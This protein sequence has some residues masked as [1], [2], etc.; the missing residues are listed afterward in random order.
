LTSPDSYSAQVTCPYSSTSN[1]WL[2]WCC[3]VSS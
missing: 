1:R 2:C 3:S